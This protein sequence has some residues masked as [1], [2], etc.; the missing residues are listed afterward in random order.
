MQRPHETIQKKGLCQ[1]S[2]TVPFEVGALEWVRCKAAKGED[3]GSV[4]LYVTKSE[5]RRQRRR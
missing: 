5:T 1:D 2:N 4:L 3:D